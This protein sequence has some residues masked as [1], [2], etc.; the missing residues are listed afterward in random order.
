M[1]TITWLHLS[2]FH[3]RAGEQHT[4]NENIVLDAL[5]VDVR[6]RIA[7][8]R[9]QPDFVVVSGDLAFSGKPEEYALAGAFLD[10]LLDATG[11]PKGRLFLVPGNHDVDRSGISLG[12]QAI[13]NSLADRDAVNAIL[14]SPA[15]RQLLFARFAGY[16]DFVNRTLAGYLP[17]DD[18]H[19]FY[20][21]FFDLAGRRL[22]LLG[23]N[24]A[25][26]AASDEDKARGLLLGERQ[27]RAAL[28]EAD[29]A[30]ATLKIAL[31]H[32]PF[33]WLR[34]FD[35]NDSA[36]LLTDNCDFILHGH[37]HQTAA[38][39]L[40]SPD[41]E[42]TVLACGAC[43]KTRDYPNMVNWVRLDLAAGTG[44]VYL[45]RYSDARGGFWT[46]DVESYRNTPDG[47]Y[48]FPLPAHLAPAPEPAVTPSP[49]WRPAPASPAVAGPAG[50]RFRLTIQ[51]RSGEGWPVVAEHQPPGDALAV[52]DDGLLRLDPAALRAL[53]D[54]Y[55]YGLALGQAL[56]QGDVQR[57][58]DQA[59]GASGHNLRVLLFVEAE[60]LRTLYWERLCARLDL[61]WEFI[62][63]EQR[64]PFSLALPSRADRLFPPIG[65]QEL[66][67]L[68]L[69]ASPQGLEPYGL[70][71][72]DT[73][74]TIAS[75]QAAL[76]PIPHDLLAVHT[77]AAGP[78]T[79]DALVDRLIDGR[80]TLLHLVCHGSFRPQT[81]ETTLYL[82]TG[83]DQVDPVLASRLLRRLGRLRSAGSLPYFAFLATCESASPEAEGALGGLAHRLVRDLGLPAV[84]AMTQQVTLDTAGALAG[85]FYERLWVHGEP[86][87]ALVEA[88]ARLAARG[89]VTVPAL[90]SRL[91]GQPLFHD[92]PAGPAPA[93]SGPTVVGDGSIAAGG[94]AVQAAAGATVVFAGQGA[95]VTID[96]PA[97]RPTP[98]P[99][100]PEEPDVQQ[101]LAG[102]RIDPDDPPYGVL[103]ELLSAA[104]EP[105][106]LRRFLEVR[107]DFRPVL[108]RVGPDVGLARIIDELLSYC[109][110]H[111]LW[112]DL[113]TE[114]AGERPKQVARF[115][116]RLR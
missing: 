77:D 20:T 7:R 89:D 103:R 74:G 37:L 92:A 71:P 48:T 86:D 44:T 25:W 114:L 39:R 23:L 47:V 52:R 88:G 112:D 49:G 115:A 10:Q 90:Y 98:P 22:A 42:A 3:F 61:G 62:A 60:D 16:G 79:L 12:A 97:E 24:S 29:D 106:D 85:R 5:L 32:H 14:A 17:F 87:R 96:R 72:F 81:G 8:D 36:A 113:L 13:A 19:F 102:I 69:V 78:P 51:R 91:D 110:T 107:R 1:N 34:E 56:F 45:R 65:R 57:A 11:L 6:E 101:L 59:L 99:P 40:T 76:E 111:L 31:L 38:T 55:E 68:V 116:G 18:E 2:D 105:E 67:A 27:T 73:Q 80:Y 43:Y 70:R 53:T 30:G 46:K 58:F 83:D 21:R 63:L 109:R 26:V 15:D 50:H 75:V 100:P 82:S 41:G 9:L 64:L 104:F 28:R 84:L 35:Q 108:A 94:H 66:R 4:W 93:P 33:D 54:P 95:A